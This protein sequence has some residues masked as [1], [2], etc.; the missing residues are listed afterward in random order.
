MCFEFGDRWYVVVVWVFSVE[1]WVWNV[2]CVVEWV[3][4][5]WIGLSDV[6]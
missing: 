5:V 1:F 2:V 3:V 4:E 6:V